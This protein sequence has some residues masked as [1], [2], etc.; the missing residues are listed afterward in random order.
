MNAQ[1]ISLCL[2]VERGTTGYLN[3]ALGDFYEKLRSAGGELI[4]AGD[5]TGVSAPSE[6]KLISAP[7]EAEA[8]RRGCLRNLSIAQA[9]G[10]LII[11]GDSTALLGP[12]DWP[13]RLLEWGR[14]IDE[15][16]P[17]AFGFQVASMA[18]EREWDWVRVD[19]KNHITLVDYGEQVG[20]L[21]V[22]AGYIGMSRPAWELSG[23]FRQEST[24]PGEEIEFALRVSRERRVP[25]VFC[26]AIDAVRVFEPRPVKRPTVSQPARRASL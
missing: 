19:S 6:V 17:Y 23:G 21:S 12:S 15:R 26:D 11:S 9:R 5:L 1:T 8:R 4:V 16:V 10:K 22:G 24:G 20:G 2:L 18:G 3:V 25:L 7:E 14:S 13:K